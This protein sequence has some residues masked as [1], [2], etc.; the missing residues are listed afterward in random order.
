LLSEKGVVV[1]DSDEE[2]SEN[3]ENDVDMNEET[4]DMEV[5]DYEQD[6]YERI[7]ALVKLPDADA[8]RTLVC[9]GTGGEARQQRIA[10]LVMFAGGCSKFLYG[11]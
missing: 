1:E 6:L 9:E 3:D 4:W 7:S 10:E 8:L 11:I 5:H 2:E